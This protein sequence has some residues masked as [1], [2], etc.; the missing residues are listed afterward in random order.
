[1][2][3][4][5]VKVAELDQLRP[6]TRKLCSVDDRRIALFNLNGTIYA[7]DNHCTHRD[8]PV[9][10][11]QLNDTVITCP[12]HGWQ[13]NVATGQ[14]LEPGG[15]NLRQY[16]VSVEGNV[17]LI[18][19]VEAA[20]PEKDDGI[21]SC[22]VRYGVMGHVSRVGSNRLIPCLRGDSVLVNTDRGVEVGEVLEAPS[23]VTGN[24]SKTRPAGELLRVMSE[25]D[26][27]EQQRLDITN[28]SILQMCSEFIAARELSITV[29]DVE[30]LFDGET[31]IVHYLG[32]PTEKLGPVAVELSD[33]AGNRRVQ[34][35]RIE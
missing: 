13:F 32:E 19:F 18:D 33:A 16:P 35:Q 14:C 24:T 27:R 11:G 23:S 7:I 26:Q 22:L 31:I 20:S 21:Y 3:T 29:I 6:G 12:W 30:Q 25:E 10:A 4:K 9:G 1:M 8:G 2:T 5:L 17:V 15:K 34:F 28:Q